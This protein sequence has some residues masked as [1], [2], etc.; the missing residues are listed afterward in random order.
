MKLND[1]KSGSKKSS[2]NTI[3][4]RL[5]RESEIKFIN[6]TKETE[7]QK[8]ID[9]LTKKAILLDSVKAELGT[10]KIQRQEAIASKTQAE[11]ASAE[12]KSKF[13]IMANSFNQYEKREPQIKK[14]IEQHRD[15]NGQVAELQSKLQVVIEEHDNKIDALNEKILI[16]N[17]LKETLHKAEL[18]ATKATQ[19]KLEAV[20]EK[21][22]IEKNLDG[23]TKKHDALGIINQEAK[24][25]LSEARHERNIFEATSRQSKEERDKA[26]ALA[27]K[28]QIWGEKLESKTS[29]TNSTSRTLTKENKDLKSEM[30]EMAEAIK[31]LTGEL[32]F[33][34]KENKEMLAELKK[35]RFASVASISKKEGF[36]FPTAYAPRPNSLGTGKPTLLKKKD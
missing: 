34:S 18:S 7:Y 10:A 33:I 11:N 21:E 35:P 12:L 16:I 14:I 1:F 29:S 2:L 19:G 4:K 3:Q 8:Q 13:N 28:L 20:M 25:K 32:F 24:D 22:V 15:L 5:G 30:T 26:V 17:N 27:Q 6:D 36:K 31:D 23:I 9:T